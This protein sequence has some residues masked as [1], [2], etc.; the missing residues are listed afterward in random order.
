MTLKTDRGIFI[1]NTSFST[2]VLFL[3][4]N[5]PDTTKQV[6]SAIKKV[7]PPRLYVAADGPRSDYP[8]DAES[9]E[10][11][12]SIATNVDWDCEVKT[13]FRE[14]NLGCKLAASQAI[15]WFFEQELEGIILEDD[16]LPDQSFF[17]FCQEL[18]GKYRDDTRI[19]HI[20]GTNFQFGKER[21]KYSYYFSRYTHLWGWAS[22]RRAWKY[23]DVKLKQWPEGKK[24]EILLNL[25]DDRRFINFWEILFE[26]STSGEADCWDPQWTFAC[27]SQN[28]L[29]VVP[30]VNLVTNLGF[31]KKSTH[32]RDEKSELAYVSTKTIN[33]PMV[34]PNFIVRHWKADRYVECQQFSRPPLSRLLQKFKRLIRWRNE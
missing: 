24:N 27:W 12:R 10:I 22:W 31:S 3:I 26:K 1:P 7:K 23:Y 21:T 19:M 18:L 32:T 9:C 5:R 20:G 14:N 33:F 6:F 17:W 25:A 28:G 29:S 34:H 4:F 16:C 2:P 13:F 15:D 11:A 30:S 8:N